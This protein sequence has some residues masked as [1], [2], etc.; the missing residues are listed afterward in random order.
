MHKND[1]AKIT[2]YVLEKLNEMRADKLK[3]VPEDSRQ[4]IIQGAVNEDEF[5]HGPGR[6]N[7][8]HFYA[9]EESPYFKPFYAYLLFK[10]YPSSRH[11]YTLRADSF[12]ALLEKPD[13]NKKK[14]FDLSGRLLHHIQDM[15]TPAH[16]IPIYHGPTMLP[17][18]FPSTQD[19][20]E[21][22]SRT[23][24]EDELKKIT[25]PDAVFE[26]NI[27][28][29]DWISL[30]DHTA[31]DTIQYLQSDAA[32]F[33]ALVDGNSASV[34]LDLFWQKYNEDEARD[35]DT[36]K[37]GFG[38]YGPFGEKFGSEEILVA[39]VVSS[40]IEIR[41]KYYQHI[42]SD[43]LKKMVCDTIRCIQFVEKN[44]QDKERCGSY[45][46]N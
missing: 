42:Y 39:Q 28:Q 10:I 4:L 33:T 31:S 35:T 30:Y 1:H 19:G 8:W 21:I 23:V 38:G 25:I 34:S 37:A 7:N 15:S 45:D 14:L 12:S 16:V 6:I 44:L 13:E 5:L 18:L 27:K 20:F 32:K 36:R 40:T 29:K 17:L 43:L 24:I 26:G 3:A 9:S 11:L 46:C 2:S 41:L 22:Y